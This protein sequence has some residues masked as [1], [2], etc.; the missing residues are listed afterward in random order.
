M[1][2]SHK[3]YIRQEG[4]S[5]EKKATIRQEG[6]YQTRRQLS[7]FAYADVIIKKNAEI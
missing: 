1:K 2:Y 7:Q 5:S 6:N 3:T 4:S